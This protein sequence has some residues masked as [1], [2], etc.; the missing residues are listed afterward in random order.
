MEKLTFLGGIIFFHFCIGVN[1][2]AA[3]AD[4][5]SL[6]VTAYY[7]GWMQ[8]QYN[9]GVLPVEEIDFTT[10]T[11]IIHFSIVPKPDGTLDTA[12]N[13]ITENNSSVLVSQAHAAG[14]KAIICV[15]GWGSGTAFK[16][17]ASL[18]NQS[19]FIDNLIAFMRNRSYDGIDIDWEPLNTSD[20]VQYTLFITELRLRLN[21]ISP[22]PLLTAAVGGSKATALATL[23]NEFDQINVMTY[24]FSGA[25]PGWVTWHNTPL[26]NGEERFPSTGAL[27]P[28]ADDMISAYITS[29]MPAKK[30]G[31][32]IDFYG[33]VWSGGNGTSTGGVTQ[34]LQT[35]GATPAVQSNVPY[36]TIMEK[37]YEPQYLRWDTVAHASY[38]SINEPGSSND[39]FISYEDEIA[40]WYKIKYAREK[41]LG[42]IFIWELGGGYQKNL[43]P[44]LKDILLQS[45]K[46]SYDGGGL[47][48]PPPDVI[49]PSVSITEPA[50]GASVSGTVTLA[51]AASDSFGIDWVQFQ[52]NGRNVGTAL[53]VPPYSYEWNTLSTQNGNY[54]ISVA[55]KDV[56]GNKKNISQ[57][58]TVANNIPAAPSAVS[59]A[60]G[61]ENIGLSPTLLWLPVPGAT[62]Y[63]V[64]V[65]SDTGF[66]NLAADKRNIQDTALAL[67]DLHSQTTYWWRVRSLNSSGTS[68]YSEP[69]RFTTS[70]VTSV[71]PPAEGIPTEFI[72]SQNYPNPFNNG[73]HITFGLPQPSNV[74]ITISD[75][76][77]RTIM[78]LSAGLLEAG[79]HNVFWNATDNNGI[80]V[81]SGVYLYHISASDV[82]G[83]VFTKT[84]K[85]VMTK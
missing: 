20:I 8:G 24:D 14:K 65:A 35:W 27:L 82:N 11:H 3:Q 53:R 23:I 4:S 66:T 51:A 36:T 56:S 7:A 85:M 81:S 12:I 40:I 32:G 38:L 61:S 33:Y 29:G 60:D 64:Q 39:K 67:T 55:A 78:S 44:E 17:A 79:Y 83:K 68:P 54:S 9:N 71:S 2:L 30:L 34:P 45:L 28:A 80:S 76:T 50:Q 74:K 42:G 21:Q 37:Y 52:L 46:Q 19:I 1:H 84:M 18:L 5:S 48:P 15:G 62:G 72:L 77:G 25:W 22:Q 47:P 59:P 26:F 69:W 13:S 43:A 10:L 58:V 75:V 31:V 70:S 57:S 6:W 16:G 49:P 63:D 41:G 73:T